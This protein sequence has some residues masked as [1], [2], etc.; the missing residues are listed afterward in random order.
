MTQVWLYVE[1]RPEMSRTTKA[2][3]APDRRITAK[4]IGKNQFIL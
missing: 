4:M 3:I 2:M 1:S